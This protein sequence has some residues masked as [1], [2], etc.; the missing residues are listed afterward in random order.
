M[1]CRGRSICHC[2][3]S[4]GRHFKNSLYMDEIG[5]NFLGDKMKK[6][7]KNPEEDR[8]AWDLIDEAKSFVRSTRKLYKTSGICEFT[9]DLMILLEFEEYDLP[10]CAKICRNIW[11]LKPSRYQQQYCFYA[12]CR[13]QHNF[14]HAV[15]RRLL[16]TMGEHHPLLNGKTFWN[17]FSE[18]IQDGDYRMYG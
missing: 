1:A 3:M 17:W 2:R 10:V 4:S 13:S 14:C 7:P 15:Y 5:R 16:N 6:R 8:Q 11:D 18:Y 9:L 12:H